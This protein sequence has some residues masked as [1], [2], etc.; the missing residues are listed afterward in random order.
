MS[1]V[2]IGYLGGCWDLFHVGHLN[3]IREAKKHCDYLI[4]D[5][6][7]D[8]IMFKQKNKYPIIGEQ[9]RLAVI[10]AIK[11]VD[12]AELS[13]DER[14]FGALKKYGFNI[15]FLSEDHKGKSYYNDIEEKMKQLGVEV[16]YIPYTKGI[17]STIIREDLKERL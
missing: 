15:L 13:D 4:V 10:R 16:I 2:K 9:N 12:R 14:D 5:V 6:T 8:E 11:Y 1:K 17:S 7:P 3:Y